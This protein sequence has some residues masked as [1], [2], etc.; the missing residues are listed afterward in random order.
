MTALLAASTA[1]TT[2]PGHYLEWG[3]I[4]VSVANLIVIGTMIVVFV[5]AIL[6]PFPH[7][8]DRS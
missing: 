8:K 4:S 6:L 1:A 5:L 2:S 3:V 7:G